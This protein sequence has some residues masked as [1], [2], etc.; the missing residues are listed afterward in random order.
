VKAI[1]W[2]AQYRGRLAQAR[3]AAGQGVDAARKE[4]VSIA[5]DQSVPYQDRAA[6]ADGL[7][8]AAPRTLGSA[9]LDYLAQAPGAAGSVNPDQPFF[10]A[11]RMKAARSLPPKEQ[12]RLLRAA[13]EDKPYGDS[14]RVPLLKAASEA[15]DYRL[16][17]AVMRLYL[18]PGW[19]DE[20]DAAS[21]E[22]DHDPTASDEQAP[23]NQRNFA[24]LPVKERAEI[25]R[26]LGT[27]L[28]M[29]GSPSDAVF[30]L[31]QAYR[32][33]TDPKIK[34]QLDR[35]VQQIRF[36]QRRQ[37][38]NRLRQPEFHAELEQQHIVRPRLPE[39]PVS[40]P[41]RPQGQNQKGAGQ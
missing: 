17:L 37:A 38:A 25:N 40:S 15:G 8:G 26:D 36:T 39:L 29:T 16:A 12:V 6:F 18:P 7:Q 22:E 20:M 41:P 4:L 3:I 31:R 33:E 28:V 27:A 2:N 10:F 34:A 30:Y 23:S 1:P 19:R 35:Q 5:S 14:A 24:G 13:L 11:A 32:L 21:P 9:E